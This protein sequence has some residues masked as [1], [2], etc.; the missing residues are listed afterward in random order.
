MSLVLYQTSAEHTW[1]QLATAALRRFRGGCRIHGRKT[2]PTR[3]SQSVTMSLQLHPFSQPFSISPTKVNPAFARPAAVRCMHPHSQQ[4]PQPDHMRTID[5]GIQNFPRNNRLGQQRWRRPTS[6]KVVKL[7]S[8]TFLTEGA[9]CKLTFLTAECVSTPARI[10]IRHPSPASGSAHLCVQQGAT[11]LQ[12]APFFGP[13][14]VVRFLLSLKPG[15]GYS[16][17]PYGPAGFSG[18]V[19]WDSQPGPGRCSRNLSTSAAEVCQ[20]LSSLFSA[21][22][23][24]FSGP[25]AAH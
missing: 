10:S 13:F 4:W 18:P 17:G 25:A 9:V 22:P 3:I 6:G 15:I 20:L 5:S 12:L 14:G 23:A 11:C 7:I 2:T 8:R 1:K 19:T 24:P 16:I 21:V